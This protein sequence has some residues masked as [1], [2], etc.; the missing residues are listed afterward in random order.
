MQSLEIFQKFLFHLFSCCS[1]YT[2]ENIASRKYSNIDI[3]HKDVVKSSL[4]LIP[5]EG[6]RHPNFPGIRHCQVFNTTW[7]ETELYIYKSIIDNKKNFW[8]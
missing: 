4:L 2:I 1:P 3:R 5:E 7:M 6:V 8:L